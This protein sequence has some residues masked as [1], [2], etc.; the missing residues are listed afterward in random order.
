LLTKK[1]SCSTLMDPMY[2][3][4]PST[5]QHYLHSCLKSLLPGCCY[6]CF[7]QLKDPKAFHQIQIGQNYYF[8]FLLMMAVELEEREGQHLAYLLL[9][10]MAPWCRR[11]GSTVV[12]ALS[13]GG[14]FLVPGAEVSLH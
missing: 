8:G 13:I 12:V 1:K 6:C 2:P 7:S 5:H 4:V 9:L 14:H 10:M 11:F 3:Q